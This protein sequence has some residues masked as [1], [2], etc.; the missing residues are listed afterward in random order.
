MAKFD[1]PVSNPLQRIGVGHVLNIVGVVGSALI[2]AKRLRVVRA[3]Q[4]TGDKHGS[5]VAMS[6]FWLVVPLTIVGI[7]EAF[8]LPGT[9][10][11]VLSRVSNLDEKYI[12][13]R[14]LVVNR[15]GVLFKYRGHRIGMPDGINEGSWLD[16]VF[17]ML[18][19]YWIG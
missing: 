5:V 7:G 14:N 4:L 13:G 17:W 12:H 9:S 16:N 1:W 3:H 2:E 15:N 6:A 8:H 18:A 10:G 19:L 11:I